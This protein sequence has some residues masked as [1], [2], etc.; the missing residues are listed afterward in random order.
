MNSEFSKLFGPN[1][2]V[3]L[4]FD[5]DEIDVVIRE[6]D[7]DPLRQDQIR[8]ANMAVSLLRHDWTYKW[9]AILQVTGLEP[10]ESSWEGNDGCSFLQSGLKRTQVERGDPHVKRY[11]RVNVNE[12]S[13][14]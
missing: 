2:V 8:R 10:C 14:S 6:L 13:S 1:A 11:K 5:S 7:N 4:P 12:K 9:E 3:H